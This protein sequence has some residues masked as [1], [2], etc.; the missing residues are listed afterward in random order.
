MHPQDT[1]GTEALYIPFEEEIEEYEQAPVSDSSPLLLIVEDNSEARRLLKNIFDPY[2]RVIDAKDGFEGLKMAINQQPDVIISD[3]M[4]P[5]MSGTQMCAKLKR[6]I[7]TSHIP[8]ILLTA[9]TAIEYKIE[10]I[11]TGADDYITKPFNTKLL[12]AR[13]RNL[14]L[15]RLQLQQKFKSDP[16]AEIKDVAPNPMDQKILMQGDRN[17]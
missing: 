8:I 10:G 2:Y 12:R 7:N 17:H 3:V 9:R 1:A 14:I 13:V 6:N 5:N 15:N 4:M 16:K 11:E